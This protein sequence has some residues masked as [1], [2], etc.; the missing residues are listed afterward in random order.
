MMASVTLTDTRTGQLRL[1][2]LGTSYSFRSIERG[3]GGSA[4]ILGT[5]G[6]LHVFDADTAA[7]TATIPA[8]GAWTEPD[9][10]QSPMPNVVVQEGIA[11]V[12][13][14]AAKKIAAVDLNKNEKVG[15]AD[16][17]HETI[18]L[19]AVTG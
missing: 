8:I 11:Y 4:V 19:A 15:E 6:A 18:E 7:K 14:P 2:D 3:P 13:D 10:W 12:S 17:P 5:D 9:E 1:V 16:L